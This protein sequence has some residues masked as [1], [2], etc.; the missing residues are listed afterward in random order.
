MCDPARH[1]SHDCES[2]E[3][4]W[5]VNMRIT[6]LLKANVLKWV[7]WLNDSL[8]ALYQM[9]LRL[10]CEICM[11]RRLFSPLNKFNIPVIAQCLYHRHPKLS[12]REYKDLYGKTRPETWQDNFTKKFSIKKPNIIAIVGR[13]LPVKRIKPLSVHELS[14]VIIKYQGWWTLNSHDP[15][16]FS[17]IFLVKMFPRFKSRAK[18]FLSFLSASRAIEALPVM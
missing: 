10:K 14:T 4:R 15:T 7:L 16:K 2:C 17:Q 13:F 5:R 8:S 9:V 18:V 3:P 12:M 6:Q 11:A 1:A